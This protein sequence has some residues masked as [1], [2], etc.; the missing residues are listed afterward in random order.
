MYYVYI[1]L[2]SSNCI[3]KANL[4][5]NK[6]IAVTRE[7]GKKKDVCKKARVSNKA[8]ICEMYSN[9]FLSLYIYLSLS[10]SHDT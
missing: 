3:F 2:F 8:D 9:F 4:T 10:F 5:Q 6:A 7:K 1:S